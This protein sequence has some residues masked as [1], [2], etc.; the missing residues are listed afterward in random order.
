[1]KRV[2]FVVWLLCSL[3][4]SYKTNDSIGVHTDRGGC[5]LPYKTPWRRGRGSLSKPCWAETLFE[6]GSHF[7]QTDGSQ[8]EQH[9]RGKDLLRFSAARLHHRRSWRASQ[10][11]TR[12]SIP[13]RDIFGAVLGRFPASARSRGFK[14]TLPCLAPR[15]PPGPRP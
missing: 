8:Q 14:R 1:M 4:Q 6:T 13:C 11:M 9:Q 7:R 3:Q 15:K 5:R 12:E 2:V 10:R